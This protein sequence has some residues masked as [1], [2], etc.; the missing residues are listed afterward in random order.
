VPPITPKAA[1]EIATMFGPFWAFWPPP[2]VDGSGRKAIPIQPTAAM[3]TSAIQATHTAPDCLARSQ[4]TF[5]RFCLASFF[6]RFASLFFRCASAFRCASFFRSTSLAD[7]FLCGV[8]SGPFDI[9]LEWLARIPRPRDGVLSG[10]DSEVCADNRTD[11]A[12]RSRHNRHD[13]L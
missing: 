6:V 4:R 7:V 10:L 1:A 12:E 9:E 3:A 13:V 5:Q 2:S 8:G 11:D